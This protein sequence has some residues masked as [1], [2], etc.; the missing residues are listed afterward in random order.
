MGVRWVA[1]SN[2]GQR[3]KWIPNV[4]GWGGEEG[5]DKSQPHAGPPSPAA[6]RMGSGMGFGRP[7]GPLGR[8]ADG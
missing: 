1:G 2:P 5:R 7:Q 6:P 8:G 4:C 3:R